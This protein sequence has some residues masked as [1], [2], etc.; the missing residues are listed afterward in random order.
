MDFWIFVLKDGELVL[1]DQIYFLTSWNKE[2][3]KTTL[4]VHFSPYTEQ[5]K[6]F[7]QVK[8]I[9]Q[10]LLFLPGMG[11]RSRLEAVTLGVV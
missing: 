7:L 8:L 9:S 5:W 11:I 2:L 3:R 4:S 1:M 6:S 10:I